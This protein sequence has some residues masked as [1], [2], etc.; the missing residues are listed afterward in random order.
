[1]TFANRTES[2]INAADLLFIKLVDSLRSNY[3]KAKCWN[4]QRA[5]TASQLWELR[6][7]AAKGLKV[8]WSRGLRRRKLD[9]S[10]S[11]L[12]SQ[13]TWHRW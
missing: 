1:M 4:F 7:G 3:S 8:S 2:G 10:A 11:L 13:A 6:A 5:P 12:T 9:E